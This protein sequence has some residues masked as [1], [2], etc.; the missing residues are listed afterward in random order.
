M[1]HR[2][3]LG[4]GARDDTSL[5]AQLSGLRGRGNW[6]FLLPR[7][8]ARREEFMRRA[9]EYVDRAEPG[10]LAE[11]VSGTVTQPDVDPAGQMPHW[12]FGFDAVGMA[13]FRTLALLATHGQAAARARDEIAGDP[14][15]GKICPTCG[16]RARLSAVMADDPGHP[17]AE[18]GG[19]VA[20]T[21]APSPRT[22]RPRSSPRSLPGRTRPV[23]RRP[24]ASAAV[25]ERATARPCGTGSLQRRARRIS[26]SEPGPVRREHY[27]LRHCSIGTPI[28]CAGLARCT[29]TGRCSRP[30]ATSESSLRWPASRRLGTRRSSA[31][32]V[33]SRRDKGFDRLER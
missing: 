16:L 20:G 23:G 14:A 32:F 30:L 31:E 21:R 33:V 4:D 24:V 10:S 2:I 19:D 22:A 28:P 18:R 7:H 17:A 9:R 8:R 29:R 3:V 11:V 25:A 15:H 1:V 6:A 12:L 27:P 5:T 26:R 13:V